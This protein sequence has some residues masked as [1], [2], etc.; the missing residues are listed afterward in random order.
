M[1][2]KS[3]R[4]QNEAAV[5][6]VDLRRIA[7]ILERHSGGH[8]GLIAILEDVQDEYGYLPES[9]LRTAAKETGRSLVDIYGL[10]TFYR[11]FS[12]EPKGRHVVCACLGTACHV[13]GAARIV[14]E[15]ERLLGIKASQTTA[16]NEFTLETVNC[17][18]A[19][20]LG[21]VVVIDGRYFSKVKRSRVAQLLE[22][23]RQGFDE[24]DLG[25]DG[26]VFPVQLSCPHCSQSLADDGVLIDGYPSIRLNVCRDHQK[27]WVRLSSLYGSYSVS[28]EF[29][30][31][32]ETVVNLVCPHCDVE[33]RDGSECSTCGAPMATMH[34]N[35]GGRIQVCTRRGCKSHMLDLCDER[36]A[37]I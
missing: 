19:C 21:P 5:R 8:G 11:R 1:A 33:L 37:R 34:V 27:G 31:P 23:A 4:A 15:L 25:K 9:V 2:Q 17:L 16:D 29:D 22:G 35:G 6:D 13:R 28:T 3:K 30:I 24:G 10:A 7:G 12:L 36:A 18:G 32:A 26:R 14:E 20:A